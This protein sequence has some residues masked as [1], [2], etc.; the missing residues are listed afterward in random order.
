MAT[1]FRPSHVE[2]STPA[3]APAGG[4]TAFIRFRDRVRS[5]AGAAEV[6]TF[7]IG[8]ERY[9]FDL[10]AVDEVVQEG[11]VTALPEGAAPLLGVMRHRGRSLPVYDPGALLGCRLDAGGTV[12]VMC[13]GSRRLGLM[14]DDVDDV[15][16]VA[17]DGVIAPPRVSGDDLLLGVLWREGALTSLVDARALVGACESARRAPGGGT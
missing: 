3:P 4:D 2:T 10:R 12:L 5:R 16:H 14:V 7:R 6:L 15:E 13:N 1:P 11:G 8:D 9:A 17:L